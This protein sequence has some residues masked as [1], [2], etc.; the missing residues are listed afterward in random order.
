V[1]HV[2]DTARAAGSRAVAMSSLD[3][4]AAAHRVYERLGF[5]REPDR[6]WSPVPGVRLIAFRKPLPD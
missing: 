2:L 3:E 1:R 5:V 4:M 6:D